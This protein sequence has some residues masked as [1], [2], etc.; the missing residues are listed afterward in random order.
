MQLTC[1]PIS[2]KIC[3]V[4]LMHLH[5]LILLYSPP[6]RIYFLSMRGGVLSISLC[7]AP[8]GK[9][10]PCLIE[11]PAAQVGILGS[12]WMLRV[13]CDSQDGFR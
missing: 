4:P 1:A 5:L 12:L 3:I 8:G 13:L 6:W 2:V 7:N 10:T 11:S 9:E